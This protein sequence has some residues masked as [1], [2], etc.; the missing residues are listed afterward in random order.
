VGIA[1]NSIERVGVRLLDSAHACLEGLTHIRC[2]LP[3]IAP[4]ASFGNLKAV[5]F[6]KRSRFVVSRKL[7]K[8]SLALFV[9][10]I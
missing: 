8:G 1:K 5:V 2:N 4:V 3:H 9:V 6:R 7:G 10:N